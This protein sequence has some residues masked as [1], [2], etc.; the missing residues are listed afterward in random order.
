LSVVVV[1]LSDRNAGSIFWSSWIRVVVDVSLPCNRSV[2]SNERV[3]E[4]V[5]G[6]ISVCVI[7][8]DAG[9][10]AT[11]SSVATVDLL[12]VETLI[13]VANVVTQVADE[14]VVLKVEITVNARRVA[15]GPG[16]RPPPRGRPFREAVSAT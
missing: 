1:C 2:L 15:P 8:S 4:E 10:D 14:A 3:E 9:D 11:S 12:L 5:R 13:T 7:T 16:F 6:T